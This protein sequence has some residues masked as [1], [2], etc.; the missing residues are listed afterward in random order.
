[1][2]GFV[3]EAKGL[4]PDSDKLEALEKMDAL[5][6]DWLPVVSAGEL[7]GIVERSALTASMLVDVA[8]QLRSGQNK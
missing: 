2:P 7:K 5:H 3:S 6:M 8:R 1:L 4:Q